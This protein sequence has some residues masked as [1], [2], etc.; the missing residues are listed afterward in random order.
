MYWLVHPIKQSN[1]SS[2]NTNSIIYNS[3]LQNKGKIPS[4]L[5]ND[6][7][8]SDSYDDIPINKSLDFAISQNKHLYEENK[9]ITLEILRIKT[10]KFMASSLFGHIYTNFF[11]IV[12]IFSCG[13]FIYQTYL[14]DDNVTNFILILFILF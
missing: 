4:K 8:E 10:Q 13:Q 5:F 9:N 14:T 1:N 7:D 6:D 2:D 3:K 12:S 11:L